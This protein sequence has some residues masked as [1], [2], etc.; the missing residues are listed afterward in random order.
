MFEKH[1]QN[2][3]EKRNKKGRFSDSRNVHVFEVNQV[4]QT[5]S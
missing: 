2:T 5:F 4:K 3:N 1:F